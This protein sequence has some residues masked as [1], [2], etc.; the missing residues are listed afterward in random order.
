MQ[1]LFVLLKACLGKFRLTRGLKV[2][3]RGSPGFR[4]AQQGVLHNLDVGEGTVALGILIGTL[5]DALVVMANIFP[6]AVAHNVAQ[7]GLH[8]FLLQVVGE[9]DLKT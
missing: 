5:A 7:S 4:H 9:N 3:I 2:F 1:Q 8:K 6:L